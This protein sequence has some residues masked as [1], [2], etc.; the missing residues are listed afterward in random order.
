MIGLIRVLSTDDETV[1]HSH[2]RAL[3]PLVRDRIVTRAIA[4]QPHGIHDDVTFAAAV[5][6]IVDVGRQLEAEGATALILSC[7]AD[8]GIAELRAAVGIPVTGAGSAGAAIARATSDRVGVL[9]IVDEVPDSVRSVLGDT[10][11][12]DRVPDGVTCTT[13]LMTPSGRAS[14]IRAAKEL[15]ADGARCILF[16]CTG[17]T[18]IGAAPGV[19]AATAHPVVDAVVAAGHLAGYPWPAR[20]AVIGT[21][22]VRVDADN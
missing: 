16:A 18:T 12:A 6:K 11:V 5:P 15:I 17:L 20:P 14:T 13:D 9:G 8:P 22:P 1:L 7:A 10:L 3:A 4:D 2:A 21:P 19:T